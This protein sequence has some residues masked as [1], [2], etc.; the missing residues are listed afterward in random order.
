LKL[1]WNNRPEMEQQDL[2][3][4]KTLNGTDLKWNDKTLNGTRAKI[5][6][7]PIN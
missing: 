5:E 2:K 3:W 1:K 4:N 7:Q 6:Q